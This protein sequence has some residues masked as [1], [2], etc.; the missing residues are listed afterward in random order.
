[1][2]YIHTV[3]AYLSGNQHYQSAESDSIALP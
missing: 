2:I 1:L 3:L